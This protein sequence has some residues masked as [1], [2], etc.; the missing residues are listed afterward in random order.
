MWKN[1]LLGRENITCWPLLLTHSLTSF[2]WNFLLC[3][4]RAEIDSH[5]NWIT[6]EGDPFD[7]RFKHKT[8]RSRETFYQRNKKTL[9]TGQ[10][11]KEITRTPKTS[12]SNQRRDVRITLDLWR[13]SKED[14]EA[15]D[16]SLSLLLQDSRCCFLQG[17]KIRKT[18]GNEYRTSMQKKE[19]CLSEFEQQLPSLS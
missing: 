4:K 8:I 1:Y 18:R 9:L 6:W 7:G 3:K 15:E 11:G 16:I 12:L 14:Q 17:K 19:S 2:E 13:G 5:C 10:H